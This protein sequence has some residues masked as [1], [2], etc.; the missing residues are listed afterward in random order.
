MNRNI[1]VYKEILSLL[2]TLSGGLEHTESLIAEGKGDDALEMVYDALSGIDSIINALSPAMEQLPVNNLQ[3]LE[4]GMSDKFNKFI[5]IFKMKD[6]VLLRD[7]LA[8]DLF[9]AFSE[10]RREMERLLMPFILA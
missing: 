6:G 3:V 1:E 10:W 5:D 7:Y 8:S 9:P 4:L 2:D